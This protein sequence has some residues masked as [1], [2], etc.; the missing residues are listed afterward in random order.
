[1]LQDGRPTFPRQNS[2]KQPTVLLPFVSR[3]FISCFPTS[4]GQTDMKH[5]PPTQPKPGHVSRKRM[6]EH[7][8]LGMAHHVDK[9]WIPHPSIFSN[10]LCKPQ[11]GNRNCNCRA[12]NCREIRIKMAIDA[13]LKFDL[14]LRESEDVWGIPRS[15]LQQRV[16]KWRED[17]SSI[18]FILNE[19]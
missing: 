14:S 2:H 11:Q 5:Q 13:C 3:K 12:R 9:G 8:L 15:T 17:K 18:Q 19:N 6:E 7:P 16:K 4:P 1:M 10:P